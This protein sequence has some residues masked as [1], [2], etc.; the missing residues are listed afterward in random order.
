MID[1]LMDRWTNEHTSSREIEGKHE[2]TRP[3][4]GISRKWLGRSGIYLAGA[5]KPPLKGAGAVKIQPPP[6]LEIGN[7]TL[8]EERCF[9][10]MDK[11]TMGQKRSNRRIR[12]KWSLTRPTHTAVLH[13]AALHADLLCFAPLHSA[14][15]LCAPLRLGACSWV[16]KWRCTNESLALIWHNSTHSEM[17]EWTDTVTYWMVIPQ[18]RKAWALLLCVYMLAFVSVFDCWN[19]IPYYTQ[20]NRNGRWP[21][22]PSL[23]S[24]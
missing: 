8:I 20:L 17:E 23:T 24:F 7:K 6:F 11:C 18:L 3:V 5:V 4:T 1:E 16:I 22:E 21:C 15:L 12:D 9:Q 2:K 10:W 19:N 13:S 14:L